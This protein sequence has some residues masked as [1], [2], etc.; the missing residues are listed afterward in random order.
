MKLSSCILKSLAF[1]YNFAIDGGLVGAI[2]TP[3]WLPANALV[4]RLAI[5]PLV[6]LTSGG[7]GTTIQIK[8]AAL[9]LSAATLYSD[10][11]FTAASG[12]LLKPAFSNGITGSGLN[13]VAVTGTVNLDYV[14]VV[15]GAQVTMNIAVNPLS[16]GN[17]VCVVEYYSILP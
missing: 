9:N 12:D 14:P 17:F 1:N 16:A 7:G 2:N 10:V 4:T 11:A 13:P 6:N 5:L 3:V 8:C 15:T